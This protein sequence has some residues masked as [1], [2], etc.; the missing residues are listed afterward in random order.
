M[1]VIKIFFSS[2]YYLVTFRPKKMFKSSASIKRMNLDNTTVTNISIRVPLYFGDKKATLKAL[3][4]A[5]GN[6]GDKL[7][8]EYRGFNLNYPSFDTVIVQLNHDETTWEVLVLESDLKNIEKS[9]NKSGLKMYIYSTS[10]L[11]T[12]LED[13]VF[14]T[15]RK[16]KVCAAEY[17]TFCEDC[18]EPWHDSGADGMC[19]DCDEVMFPVFD[20]VSS[21]ED[22]ERLADDVGDHLDDLMDLSINELHTKLKPEPTTIGDLIA[23]QMVDK[24]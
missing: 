22:I 12:F 16:F 8:S 14:Q 18:H 7:M 15:W 21:F 17:P 11:T 9:L 19:Y 3:K 20:L 10:S 2:L 1:K 23:K 6:K 13:P 24:G 5:L 4:K